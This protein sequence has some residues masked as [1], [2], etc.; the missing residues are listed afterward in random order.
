MKLN[1]VKTFIIFSTMMAFQC[2]KDMLVN[3]I[4][5][6]RV[7]TCAPSDNVTITNSTV[8]FWWN[9]VEDATSYVVQVVSP[10]FENTHQL[11]LDTTLSA[12]KV[13][14]PLTPGKYE[15]RIK[16]INDI[17]ETKY[18]YARFSIDSTNNLNNQTLFAY[19]PKDGDALNSDSIIFSW[20]KLYNALNYKVQLR[21]SSNRIISESTTQESYCKIGIKTEG[22]YR[23]SVYGTNNESS[24]QPT[25]RTL[26]IDRTAPDS[27]RIVSPLNNEHIFSD[28]VSFKWENP[29]DTGS[30]LSDSLVVFSENDLSRPIISKRIS[31]TQFNSSLSSGTYSWKVICIDMAG[32]KSVATK[33]RIFSKE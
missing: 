23:W 11:W 21:D 4:S 19:Y 30:P 13:T 26:T 2:C 9:D 22:T 15:W 3:D 24:T 20:N 29:I 6:E 25:T 33:T 14:F 17:S 10:S 18:F 16:A 32:N 28:S 8:T 5:D 1:L 12:N 7:E 31:S 27:V